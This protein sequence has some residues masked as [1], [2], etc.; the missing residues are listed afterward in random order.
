MIQLP[1]RNPQIDLGPIG[2]N[3]RRVLKNRRTGQ[4]FTLG[5]HE[6]FLLE[7]LDGNH[8]PVGIQAAFQERFA[9]P[10]PSEDL[11]GFL[12]LALQ[13]GLLELPPPRQDQDQKTGTQSVRFAHGSPHPNVKVVGK[14]RRWARHRDIS[15]RRRKRNR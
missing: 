3:G 7:Q 14:S 12:N 5:E 4:Y 8:S 9:E 15:I 6:C 1:T 2:A 10:L 13:K 11:L